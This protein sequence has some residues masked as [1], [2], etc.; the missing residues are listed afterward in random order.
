[1][2]AIALTGNDTITIND[3]LFT[4]LA[5]GNCVELTFPNEIADLRTGKNGNSIYALKESGRQCE[6]KVIVLLGSADDN[7]LNNLLTQ[8]QNN[9]VGT[10]LLS[11]EFIKKIGDG[12]GNLTSDIY[13][14]GGGIFIKI[15]E[16]KTD[17]EGD[18]TQ[19]TALYTLRFSNAPRSLT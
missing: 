8:Q 9:F 19:S 3:Y 16:A 5:T 17:T 4:G 7:F 12:A 13:V 14:L 1:M 6:V 18:V 2:S 11:G 10:V 15:P